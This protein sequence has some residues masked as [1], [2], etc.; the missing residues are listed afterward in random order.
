MNFIGPGDVCDEHDEMKVVNSEL[1][2]PTLSCSSSKISEGSN[3]FCFPSECRVVTNSTSCVRDRL[4]TKFEMKEV[5]C[6]KCVEG[7]VKIR[8]VVETRNICRKKEENFCLDTV[9]REVR[10]RKWC[11][12]LKY[13]EA[14]SIRPRAA[15]T[16]DDGEGA[17]GESKYHIELSPGKW[18]TTT[19]RT[20]AR[21]LLIRQ[22]E[23]EEKYP[24]AYV[25]KDESNNNNEDKAQGSS[26][27]DAFLE[28]TRLKENQVIDTAETSTE[29][30]IV[31]TTT[32]NHD[33]DNVTESNTANGELPE[34]PRSAAAA[35]S[36]ASD[37]D[38]QEDG[39]INSAKVSEERRSFRAR[40]SSCLFNPRKCRFR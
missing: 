7:R 4:P 24:V 15:G 34:Q 22:K 36:A 9:D 13:G 16:D 38:Q 10:W 18:V 8:P 33:D 1:G 25:E 32:K 21:R 14:S 35:V 2:S 6:E 26:A 39:N 17:K 11:R 3:Q 19:N 20:E 31:V 28:E 12:K 27:R 30:S 23:E 5:V 29:N 37:A 40:I